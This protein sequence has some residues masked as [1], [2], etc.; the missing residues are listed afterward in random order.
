MNNYGE[1]G[2]LGQNQLLDENSPLNFAWRMVIVKVEPNFAPS[3]H[4][5]VTGQFRQSVEVFL[6]SQFCFMGMN[7]DRGVQLGEILRQLDGRIQSRSPC[8]AANGEDSLHLGLLGSLQ[9][10]G[11]VR[12]KVRGFDMSVGINKHAL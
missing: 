5:W 10:G 2:L 8:S 9:H 12:I 11:S 7:S 6:G 1:A 4:V 3:H